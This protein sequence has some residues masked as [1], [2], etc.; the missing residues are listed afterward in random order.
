MQ[1]YDN[2]GMTLFVEI[3]ISSRIVFH[4]FVRSRTAL[5]EGVQFPK[6]AF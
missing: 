2:R 5:G 6:I 4:F 3:E 1:L